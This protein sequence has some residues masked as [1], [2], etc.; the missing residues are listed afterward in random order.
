MN[1]YTWSL[2]PNWGCSDT[3]SSD[4]TLQ[5]RKDMQ[6]LDIRDLYLEGHMTIGEF[7]E[8]MRGTDVSYVM[9]DMTGLVQLTIDGVTL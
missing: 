4:L 9:D 5:D 3:S 8:L 7:T 2:D 1:Q 6:A